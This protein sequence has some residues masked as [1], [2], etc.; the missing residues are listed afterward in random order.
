MTFFHE[1]YE[2]VRLIN[3]VTCW[4]FEMMKRKQGGHLDVSDG[5][6]SIQQRLDI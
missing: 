1:S 2:T 5:L 3:T 6:T 4:S